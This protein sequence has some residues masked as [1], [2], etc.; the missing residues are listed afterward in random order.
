MKK[1]IEDLWII[2]ESGITL[3]SHSFKKSLNPFLFGA[4]MSMINKY[5]SSLSP[6]GLNCFETDDER[7][8]FEKR[9]EILFIGS[10]PLNIKKRKAYRYL[11]LIIMKF[12]EMYGK[13]LVEYFDGDISH[14][15][16]FKNELNIISQRDLPEI[17]LQSAKV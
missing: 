12:F 3:F 9:N 17:S 6:K 16:G 13:N 10:F 4:F 7:F 2:T 1:K 11:E 8:L 15:H 5:A 14:Y